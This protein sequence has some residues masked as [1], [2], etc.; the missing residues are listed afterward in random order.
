MYQ[1]LLFYKYVTV[2]DPAQLREN[3]IV[4]AA[5]LNLVGRVIVAE[6]GLNGTLE[7]T[8]ENTEDF[9]AWILALPEFTDMHIKRSGG[10]GDSFPRL[11]VKVRDEIVGTH[12]PI[13]VDAREKTSR[14]MKAEELREWYEK[15][16][17]FV[18]VD[19]RND[20]EYASGHFK[21]SIDPGM[22]NSRD[23]P[24]VMPQLEQY[25]NKKVVTVCTGGV[26]CEKMSAYLLHEGFTD[27]Q[28]LDGGIHTYMEKFPGKDFEGALYTFDQRVTQDW[29]GERS[30]VGE[31]V[32]CGAA[33]ERYINCLVAECHVHSLA[34]VQC[35]P[36]D[37]SRR[38]LQCATL[39][40]HV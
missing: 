18:V 25:K 35:A 26:R 4:K 34:C 38:C 8:R 24:S 7:G 3:I 22:K 33:T 32:F 1:V 28:Q 23:L 2:R 27:V 36:E 40:A 31:C 39:V 6:E 29:G 37:R 12:L 17:E 11:R 16:E 13:E 15:G 10:S 20:Y 14:H 19:M 30:V 9:A 21:N 5:E